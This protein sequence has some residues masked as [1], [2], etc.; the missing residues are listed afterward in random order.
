MWPHLL[1]K[2]KYIDEINEGPTCGRLAHPKHPGRPAC[3]CRRTPPW[4]S[5]PPRPPGT[6][7]PP[8]P[9]ARIKLGLIRHGRKIYGTTSGTAKSKE[10]SIKRSARRN[11]GVVPDGRTCRLR[12]VGWRESSSLAVRLPAIELLLWHEREVDKMGEYAAGEKSKKKLQPP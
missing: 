3:C 6:L 12:S 11:K 8:I 10:R 4:P 9:R 2:G 7:F 5:W 1:P